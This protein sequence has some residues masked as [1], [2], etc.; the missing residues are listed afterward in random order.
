MTR[1]QLIDQARRLTHDNVARMSGDV[2]QLR[3]EV[4][5]LDNARKRRKAAAD[6]EYEDRAAPHLAGIKDR[7]AILETWAALHKDEQP[8]RRSWVFPRA[9]IG[10][11]KAGPTV[12]TKSRVKIV[13]VVARL[14]QVPWGKTYLRQADPQLDKDALLRDRDQLTRDQLDS[15]G[16][17]FDDPDKFYVDPPNEKAEHSATENAA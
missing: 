4:Q 16:I 3:L 15:L 13:D 12:K 17:K 11:R 8:G 7:Q 9:I 1:K 5:K 2:V 6:K 10:W 14:L